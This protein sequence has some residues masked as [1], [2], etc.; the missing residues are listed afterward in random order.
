MDQATFE[1]AEAYLMG[2]LSPEDRQAFAVRLAADKELAEEVRL[3]EA[4]NK[5]L[6]DA[7]LLGFMQQVQ[8]AETSYL[9]PQEESE[10]GPRGVVRSLNRIFW[11]AASVVVLFTAGWWL[12]QQTQPKSGADTFLAL[13]APADPP[14]NYRGG[15]MDY[16]ESMDFGFSA[17]QD[18]DFAKAAQY[19]RSSLRD[20]DFGRVA[21]YYLAHSLLAQDSTQTA[22]PLLNSL[23][24]DGTT[25]YQTEAEWYLTLCY[26]QIGELTKA[27]QA[28]E[29]IQQ[30][31]RHPYQDKATSL[32]K[33][34]PTE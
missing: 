12:W 18:G 29:L 3:L 32:L 31:P 34:F 20:R 21:Q 27:R 2:T 25:V 22:L 28:A 33:N 17:Y 13:Y 30:T 19:F 15:D 9:P 14:A 5:A 4:S 10:V 16:P 8:A 1:L 23:A 24:H 26:L 11:V 7:E 6:A